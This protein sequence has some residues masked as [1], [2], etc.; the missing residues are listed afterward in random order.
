MSGAYEVFKYS[1]IN[2]HLLESLINSEIY[3]ASPDK[4]R[5]SPDGLKTV[6]VVM[7]TPIGIRDIVFAPSDPRI[8]YAAADGYLVYRSD[9]AGLTWRLLVNGRNEVLN[10]Q[11]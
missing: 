6:R 1:P 9:D 5:R 8:V 2:K 11:Q 10:A 3:F 7:N 4:L